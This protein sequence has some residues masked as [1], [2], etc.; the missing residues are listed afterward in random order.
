MS[1]CKVCNRE[2]YD[3]TFCK[4]GEPNPEQT[5]EDMFGHLITVDEYLSEVT[6]GKTG[7]DGN[8]DESGT[9]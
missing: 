9:I 8:N 4:C 2:L 5:M 1:Q 7:Q 3:S 6:D